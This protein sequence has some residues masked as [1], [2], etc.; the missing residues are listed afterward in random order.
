MQIDWNFSVGNNLSAWNCFYAF[1]WFW[2]NLTRVLV[3]VC[4]C[5]RVAAIEGWGHPC[6]SSLVLYIEQINEAYK[7]QGWLKGDYILFFLNC[8]KCAFGFLNI[9]RYSLFWVRFFMERVINTPNPFWLDVAILITPSG[10]ARNSNFLAWRFMTGRLALHVYRRPNIRATGWEVPTT[11][12]MMCN[13]FFEA[14]AAVSTYDTS[15]R[16][17]QRQVLL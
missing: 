17:L 14:T 7:M 11:P 13:G 1:D 3:F 5:S 4:C 15:T 12:W 8:L 2:S 6:G 9:A 16:Y 10:G